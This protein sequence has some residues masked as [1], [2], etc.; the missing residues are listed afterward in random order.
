MQ[1]LKDFRASEEF[2]AMVAAKMSLGSE[3]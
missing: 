3:S 1:L 2:S